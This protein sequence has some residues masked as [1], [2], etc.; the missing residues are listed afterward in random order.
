MPYLTLY[1]NNKLLI[2]D[3]NRLKLSDSLTDPCCCD[4][5][6]DI[7]H[8]SVI[9]EDDGYQSSLRNLEWCI[10]RAAFPNRKFFLLRPMP[11]VSTVGLPQN[12]DGTGPITVNRP[13]A[14]GF[15]GTPTNWFTTM[16]LDAF[17]TSKT[18]IVLAIDNSGSMTT[19]TVRPSY[20]Q[21]IATLA[22]LPTPITTAAGNLRDLRIG[23]SENL[24]CPHLASFTD[25]PGPGCT[26]ETAAMSGLE[27]DLSDCGCF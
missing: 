20:T 4:D 12:W 13:G 15:T 25:C 2:N 11:Q 10:F 16:G 3:N 18:R 19:N 14:P 22:A 9:D 27:L 5:S 8:I 6:C 1:D 21:F 26:C 7:I 23:S 17:I 24:I